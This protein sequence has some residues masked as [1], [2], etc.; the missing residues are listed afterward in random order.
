MLPCLSFNW[1]IVCV[2]KQS[3]WSEFMDLTKNHNHP[4]HPPPKKKH[5]RKKHKTHIL[6]KAVRHIL[7]LCICMF[8][9]HW[10]TTYI[11][12]IE[13]N[14]AIFLKRELTYVRT[15]FCDGKFSK[16][17][18]NFYHSIVLTVPEAWLPNFTGRLNMSYVRALEILHLAPMYLT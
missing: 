8:I 2:D 3:N 16:E 12:W 4:P 11:Y 9:L 6:K 7:I 15:I 17:N 14:L 13:C 5:T 1:S 10:R 18:N